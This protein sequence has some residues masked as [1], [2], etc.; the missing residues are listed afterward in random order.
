MGAITNDPYTASD[1]AA[2][3]PEIWTPDVNEEFFAKSVLANFVTDLSEFMSEGGD[4]AHVPG[5][6]TNSFTPKTQSTQGAEVDTESVAMDDN[7]L[8]VNTHKYIAILIGDKDMKQIARSYNVSAMWAKKMGASLMK[9]LEGSLAALWSSL[10]SHSIGDT[11]TV[12]ADA[13]VR[14][15]INAVA[16][17]DVPLDECAFFV[18]PYVYWNQLHAIAKYYTVGTTGPMNQ[19][20][21]VVTGNFMGNTSMQRSLVGFLYGIPLYT[22]TNIVSGLQTYRNLLL[23]KSAFAFAVQNGGMG[24]TKVRIQSAYALRNLAMLTIADIIYGVAVIREP[25]AV[26]LNASNAFIGS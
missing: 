22:T 21:P 12:L 25:V 23:H 5:V 16:S 26:L 8:T 4:I 17:S 6:Y 15:A 18:H 3:I 14:Q 10:S 2:I 19:Q 13:E 1:L 11:A 24:G 9:S 7:T 20:G